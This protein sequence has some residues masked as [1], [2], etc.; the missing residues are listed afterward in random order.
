MIKF[1]FEGDIRLRGAML[2]SNM[3]IQ[4]TLAFCGEIE[5]L[6]TIRC[7]SRTSFL[8]TYNIVSCSLG[9]IIFTCGFLFSD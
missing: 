9:T 5:T 4:I 7:T 8:V 3:I 2:L 6:G 1:T